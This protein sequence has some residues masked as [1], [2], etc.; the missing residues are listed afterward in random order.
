MTILVVRV[1][2]LRPPLEMNLYGLYQYING[3]LVFWRQ[4]D[5]LR[6]S[7]RLH[8]YWCKCPNLV[9]PPK[10]PN[11]PQVIHFAEKIISDL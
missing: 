1:G 2:R 8:L 5:L 3:I 7:D 6:Q 9:K 11:F 10:R 4:Q